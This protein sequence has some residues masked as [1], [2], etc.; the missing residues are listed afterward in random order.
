MFK[1]LLIL[2]ML[3]IIS[4]L[5]AQNPFQISIS[6]TT[7]AA[8]D[9]VLPF[10][11]AANQHGKIL[12]SNSFANISDLTVGQAYSYKSK[13][14]L[15][16]TWGG[17][18]VAAFG[19]NNYYQL[20]QAFA[21]LALNGW[22]IIG[23]MFYDE[24]KYAGLSTSNG[25]LVQ[26]QN[27]R[28]IPKVR[29]STPGFK[30]VPFLK[31]WLSFKG[32]Y[33]EGF[34]NDERYVDGTHLHHKNLYF[35]IQTSSTFNFKIGFE[36]YV[37][38]GGTSQD[39]NI[40][41][42]PE[43]WNAYWH[44]VFALPGGDDFPENDQLNIAGNQLGTYQFEVEKDFIKATTTF[45]LSHPFEDNSG[46][47]WHNWPDNLLG[48]HLNI[49]NKKKLITDI[50]YEFTNSRQ[51]SIRDSIYTWNEN[52][53]QWKMNEY[54]NYYNS[55]IY[56]SGF[57]YKEYV[58][59]SPL[60]YPVVK[61]N[62]I[63][64][65]IRS[66]RLF[67]HHFGFRGNFSE[68]F[69]WKGMLTFIQHFGTYSNPYNTAQKQVSGLFEVQFINPDFPLEFGFALGGDASNTVKNNLGFRFSVAKRW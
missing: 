65:G 69:N 10:W 8:T 50:V 45:Y 30:P 32:E 54:D 24:I 67:A 48:L 21:G 44:Y 11:F 46:L 52:S 43:G 40:G 55:G 19:E 63:S 4:N 41:E 34:L 23:G 59:C 36:H 61:S 49:K 17:N 3:F 16:Y 68:Y 13:S 7:V 6:N 66:N 15:G 9:S 57:T 37:M 12:A 28:P 25:I 22:E 60:F 26:S 35:K 42:L 29:F 38:W 2:F 14:K 5:K 31:N 33:E 39:E 1:Y 56:I 62:G 18:F 58:M 20:N 47:N 53:G 27:A 51:Q 64:M